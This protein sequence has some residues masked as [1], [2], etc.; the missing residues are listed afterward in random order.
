MCG[1]VGYFQ[2]GGLPPKEATLTA[3]KMADSLSHRGPDDCGVWVD[4]TAGM[5]LAHRRLAVIDLS[6]TGR[7]PMSSQSGRF[8]ISFN[9]EIYNHAELRRELDRKY[10]GAVAWKG[11][12][13]TES[14]LATIEHLGVESALQQ[15]VGMFAFG[16]WDRQDR[17]TLFGKGS[18]R[19]EAT[20]FRVAES[21]VHVRVR[22]QGHCVSSVVHRGS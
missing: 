22:A 4:E 18:A 9:G 3:S 20:I 5:A 6:V 2:P 17:D 11:T 1:I 12:S 8:V 14:L 10:P 15:S 21:G 19:R 13:D 7:Q 16:L